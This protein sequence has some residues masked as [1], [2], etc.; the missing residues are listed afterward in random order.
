MPERHKAHIGHCF[1]I[2]LQALTCSPSL[3]LIPYV[4]MKTQKHPYPDFNIRRQCV[5]HEKILQWQSVNAI[6]NI[7]EKWD[8]V[9]RPEGAFEVEAEAS[10]LNIGDDLGS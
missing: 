3:D 7:E 10:L 5:A 9:V 8:H 2:L 6:P 4:W 1:D